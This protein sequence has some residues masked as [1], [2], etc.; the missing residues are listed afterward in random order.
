MTDCIGNDENGFV[1]S[2]TYSAQH[3]AEIKKIRDKYLPKEESKLEKLIRLDK[4]AEKKGQTISITIGVMGALLLGVGMCC[5]MVWNTGVIIMIVGIV[6]GLIGMWSMGLAYPIYKKLT[7]QERKKIA[8]QI[9]A[10][11]DELL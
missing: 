6:T 3:H 8:D 2:Y 9:I 4:Q 5:N 11:S 7:E 10:L 1:Y